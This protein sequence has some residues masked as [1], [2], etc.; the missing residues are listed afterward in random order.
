MI[1]GRPDGCGLGLIIGNHKGDIACSES[2]SIKTDHHGSPIDRSKLALKEGQILTG[3]K[4]HGFL[5]LG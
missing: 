3:L 2:R 5:W 1:P 4:K